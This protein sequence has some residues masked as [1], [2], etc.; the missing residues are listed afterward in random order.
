MTAPLAA[1]KRDIVAEALEAANKARLAGRC[2][3]YPWHTQVLANEVYGLRATAEAWEKMH[4][5][6]RLDLAQQTAN[7]KTI[8]DLQREIERL[9]EQVATEYCRG[10][11]H[12][13]KAR[14]DAAKPIEPFCSRMGVLARF[15]RNQVSLA[16]R[17]PPG[18]IQLNN[19]E[20]SLCAE[21]L[22]RAS[23]LD[24]PAEHDAH[25]KAVASR[26]I[27]C[28][29]GGFEHK[30][31][32]QAP[33]YICGY[34]GPGYYAPAIHPCARTYHERVKQGTRRDEHG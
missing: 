25:C 23:A 21:A 6:L 9:R 19:D 15:I 8:I 10:R 5:Q 24:V 13:A 17:P 1:E 30:R 29:C 26:E 22:E 33:C 32:E 27:G 14:A 4:G 16:D 31:F 34:N 20:A 11:D 7:A 12:E 28:D 2:S 3:G 18:C